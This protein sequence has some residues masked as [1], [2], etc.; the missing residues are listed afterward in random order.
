MGSK[1]GFTLIELL[2]VIAIIALLISIL[3]PSL[4]QAREIA[5]QTKCQ[6]H[7][8]STMLGFLCYV[9][10][11]TEHTPPYW[12]I[13][14]KSSDPNYYVAW[15]WDALIT[16]Y[17]DPDAKIT[18]NNSQSQVGFQ[19]PNGNYGIRAPWI[20][21]SRKMNCPSRP[22]GTGTNYQ[23][24]PRHFQYCSFYAW[25]IN[26]TINPSGPPGVE[27]WWSPQGKSSAEMYRYPFF[28]QPSKYCMIDDWDYV[29]PNNPANM[30]ANLSSLTHMK[31]ASMNGGMAD[32][33]VTT[34]GVAEIR[35]WAL[36]A[37]AQQWTTIDY[38]FVMPFGTPP[39]P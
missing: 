28:R 1:H 15:G 23:A 16:P 5:R 27:I 25:N 10:E 20:V 32:G 21:Y 31:G 11:N 7:L 4:Q 12:Y 13:W 34:I 6:V 17:F 24:W 35:K 29:N 9:N 33:H 39:L 8:R 26:E 36:A 19:P 18:T 2:V 14:K 3:V 30:L 38:P 37:Q 22:F